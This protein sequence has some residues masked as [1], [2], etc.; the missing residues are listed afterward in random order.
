MFPKWQAF[1]W[2][3]TAAVGLCLAGGYPILAQNLSPP[4]P[5]S[6]AEASRFLPS[7]AA[8]EGVPGVMEWSPDDPATPPHPDVLDRPIDSPPEPPPPPHP[9]AEKWDNAPVD[10]PL[11]FTCKSSVR[12]R[13][14]Q[15]DPHFVP[16]EDRWRIGFPEWDRYTTVTG[17]QFATDVPYELGR[18]FDPYNQNVLKGD[19]PIIGQNTFLDVTGS[20]RAIVEGRQVPTPATGFDST[21][22]PDTPNFFGRPN[23]FFYTEFFS[24][25]LDLFHGDAAFKPADWRVHVTPVFD[26]NVLDVEELGVVS[27]NVLEGTSRRRTYTT[28]Q[29]WFV[30]TKLAD[31]S[32]DYDFVSIRAGSQPFTSDFRGFLF[33]DVN[34]AI[35]LFGTQFSNRDQFN[36]AVF[37]QDEKDINSFLNTNEDRHQTVL[38][39]NYYRQD[40]LFP[41]YTAQ[42][43]FHFNNDR[44]SVR[45][46]QNGF[47]V[48]PDPVGVAQPHEVDV[49]YLGWAGD[50]HIGPINITHQFYWALGHDTNNPM[51]GQAQDI[52]AQMVA[53]ELSYDRDWVRF[54]SSFL[55]ASGDDNPKNRH[56]TGFDAILDDPNFAGGDFSYWQRQQIQLLGV[57]LVNRMS[58]L[59][60]LRSNKFQ[61]QSNFVNPG[62]WL[63]NTGIDFDL[64]PKLRLITNYNLLWFDETEVLEQFVFQEKVH[65]FIGADLSAGVEY[66][67]LLSNNIIARFGVSTLIPGSGFKDLY[68]NQNSTVPPMVA[69]FMDLVLA[70]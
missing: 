63:F 14:V 68:S 37:L 8:Q 56:A 49:G 23:Q 46:D 3:R 51:A 50:G 24:L 48:R 15:T 55:W 52:N 5:L 31:L 61:G 18:L 19:Y 6:P 20:T 22:R 65:H 11:G 26:V 43:S 44:P 38:I 17:L 21:A 2:L 36:V 53:L 13:D 28:L 34:R 45:F 66:R 29:E 4:R 42:V 69:G 16:V 9:D 41:G 57:S 60:D 58:L 10:A 25:S 32:P 35:R 39:A 64:T 30:E 1:R 47:L 40:F 7:P 54:R 59:P 62:L 33:S 70:F 27:P 67:P 12:P